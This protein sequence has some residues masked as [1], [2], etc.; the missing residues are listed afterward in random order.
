M[1]WT[2][3]LLF[4]PCAVWLAVHRR[5]REWG[6]AAAALCVTSTVYHA[7]HGRI[8]RACDVAL[9]ELMGLAA[10]AR[11]VSHPSDRASVALMAM[12]TFNA[13]RSM[14]GADV[15]PLDDHLALHVAVAVG[16][17]GFGRRE[18]DS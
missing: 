4:A 6:A 17:A 11:A 1:V 9:V 15:I 16:M 8:A 10:V 5:E 13:W 2:S 12:A 14:D 18:N 7:T 3:L